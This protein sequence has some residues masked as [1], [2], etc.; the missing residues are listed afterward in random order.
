MASPKPRIN[1]G[2]FFGL[3]E[4]GV[5]PKSLK[6][7][8]NAIA[9]GARFNVRRDLV[10]IGTLGI[11]FIGLAS[12]VAHPLQTHLPPRVDLGIQNITQDTPVWCWAA[13]AQQIILALRGPAGT[14]GQCALVAVANGAAPQ[15]CCQVPT[16]CMTTGGLQQIQGLILQFGGRFSSIAPPA[17]PMTI[18]N[19]LASGR[20]VI[21]AVQSSSFSGHV[22]VIRGMEWVPTPTGPQPVLYVND[23]MS[24]FTQPVAFGQLGQYWQAAIVVF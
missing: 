11:A 19:T 23:P 22:V 8:K 1:F 14:P 2:A 17:D 6:A 18:Y 24:F 12:L 3:K 21:M 5:S 15:Y 10:R 7:L 20:A 9:L 16:P 4:K 13:V